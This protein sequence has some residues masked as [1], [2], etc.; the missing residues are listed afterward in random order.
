[1]PYEIDRDLSCSSL[2][3]DSGAFGIMQECNKF[4]KE[5]GKEWSE[6][7]HTDE[8]WKYCDDYIDFIKQ[9]EDGIDVYATLDVIPGQTP[10]GSSSLKGRAETAAK[11]TWR[12]QQYLESKGLCPMPV[13]HRG[14]ESKWIRQYIDEGYD[15]L[16]L[17]GMVAA[18]GYGT[19]TGVWD[20]LDRI[21]GEV[22]CNTEDRLPV[23]KTHGFGLGGPSVNRYPFYS[24]DSTTWVMIGS[25]GQ[26]AYPRI[27]KG[28]YRFDLPRL[29]VQVT[30]DDILASDR[31]YEGFKVAESMSGLPAFKH[32]LRDFSKREKRIVEEW[33]EYI[34]VP[35]GKHKVKKDGSIEIL[36]TG[37]TNDRDSRIRAGIRYFQCLVDSLPDYPFPFKP[38]ARKTLGVV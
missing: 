7:Y 12:N 22:I 19:A 25:Y 5:T 9:H 16:G 4:V 30:A 8:Y 27:V 18:G 10:G 36:E 29:V 1:M 21:F 17:G 2:F 15:Y 26:L 14:A 3:I 38:K 37:V 20:W 28:K 24:V 13:V 23:I 31:V 11:L 33:L 6:F 35:L 34:D 32:R